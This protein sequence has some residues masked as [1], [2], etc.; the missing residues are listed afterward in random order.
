MT[1]GLE[2][3]PVVVCPIC[4]R[5]RPG[6]GAQTICGPCHYAHHVQGRT[7]DGAVVGLHPAARRTLDAVPLDGDWH[8]YT[9]VAA[10]AGMTVEESSIW[11][12]RLAAVG[13]VQSTGAA[14]RWRR[15]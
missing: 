15:A 8:L 13:A 11:L 2:Y 9:D 7:D 12:H 6:N 10:R 3:C 4:G 5:E 1:A 14:T